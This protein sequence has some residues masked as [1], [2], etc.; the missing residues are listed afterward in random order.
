MRFCFD[1]SGP[2]SFF[3]HEWSRNVAGAR[4]ARSFRFSFRTATRRVFSDQSGSVYIREPGVLTRQW[5]EALD[6]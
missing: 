3:H 6:A 2:L 1:V 4:F 5:Q